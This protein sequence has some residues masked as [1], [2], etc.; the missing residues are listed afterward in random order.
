MAYP[1]DA[2]LVTYTVG[3]VIDSASDEAMIRVTVTMVTMGT[4]YITHKT[5]G[6]TMVAGKPVPIESTVG[7]MA[8]F[9]RPVVDQD[10]WLDSNGSPYSGWYYRVTTSVIDSR[11]NAIESWDKNIQPLR[12]MVGTIQ[13]VDRVADGAVSVPVV[14][15]P[16][17]VKTVNGA[18]PDPSGNVNVA[19]GGGGG[20]V[21]MSS[22]VQEFELR[23]APNELA[24]QDDV[25]AALSRVQ[26]VQ[27]AA[28]SGLYE[29]KVTA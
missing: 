20:D 17:Y 29:L 3:T 12:S 9:Q 6:H 11:G 28:N 18:S 25:T 26:L 14:T 2:Q 22:Y 23:G 10:L 15:P 27:T 19:G 7:G 21:D 13:D 24:T 8:T 16:I 1:S 4:K 5:T